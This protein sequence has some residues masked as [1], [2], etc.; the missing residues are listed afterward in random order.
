M[1]HRSDRTQ[2]GSALIVVLVASIMIAGVSYGFLMT[3]AVEGGAQRART[4]RSKAIYVAE[5]GT[6]DAVSNVLLLEDPVLPAAL[7]TEETPVP[8]GGGA[9]RVSVAQEPDGTFKVVSRGDYGRSRV[10]VETLWGRE[11]HPLRDYAIYS[12]N[13]T[14]ASNSLVLGGDGSEHDVV[15]GKVYVTGNLELGGDSEVNGKAV[16]TGTVTGNPVNGETLAGA[17]RLSPPDLKAMEYYETAD[18]RIDAATTFDSSGR[19][20]ASD[21]RHIFV[22][23]FR[24]D[25]AA[26]TGFKFNN[27]NYFLGDPWE[28]AN[29]DKISVSASGNNKVYFVDGNLWV[30]P[31]GQ[32]ATIV[33]S[34]LDGTRITVVVRG[35]IYFADDLNYHNQDKDALLFIALTDGESYRDTNGN[36][37]FDAGEPILHDDGDGTYEGPVEGS[38]NIFFGD[39]NGGP[40]GHVHGYM[41]ADNYFM[42]HVLDGTSKEPLPFEVTG[43]MS[44]GEQVQIRREFNG[45]HAK[46]TVNFDARVVDGDIQ[47]PG[48]PERES[49]GELGLLSWRLVTDP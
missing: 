26:T 34:P 48:F 33:K 47:L 49:Q 16:A 10:A 18:F 29:I 1:D 24:K 27:T 45:E 6:A 41:Y 21:P 23:E 5:A 25:L 2:R 17:A 39:P 35:N 13:R 40:L 22:K 3:V 20:A 46:M 19:I 9:Y 37:Q 15:N 38:G 43:F 44:A 42:D 12:G 14:E 28:G 36:N 7:G 32:T 11:Y 31:Q 30:E 8:F 4:E